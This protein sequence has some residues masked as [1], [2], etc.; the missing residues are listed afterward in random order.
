MHLEHYVST[1]AH[2]KRCKGVLLR[3]VAVPPARKII[4]VEGAM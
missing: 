2:Q 4:E 1:F 3:R